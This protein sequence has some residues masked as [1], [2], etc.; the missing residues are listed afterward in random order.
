MKKE[1]RIILLGPPGAGKGTQAAKISKEF[2]IP[3]LSTGEKFREIKESGSELGLKAYKIWESGN[4]VPDEMTIPWVL[5]LLDSETY[6]KGFI[7]DGFPRTVGQAEAMDSANYK[8]PKIDA[9]FNIEMML[10]NELVRRLSSRKQCKAC[11]S[12]Y[13]EPNMPSGK[14]GCGGELY[15]RDDDKPETINKR[16]R[17]YDKQTANVIGYYL[18]KGMMIIDGE[19]DIEGVFSQMKGKIHQLMDS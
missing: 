3:Y 5:E 17:V 14:C 13:G 9:V 18:H 15:Q 11:N 10:R 6:R 2:G 1:L 12:I 16:L 7:L 8:F 4:L 19:R